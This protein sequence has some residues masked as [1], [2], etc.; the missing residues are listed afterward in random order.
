MRRFL[1]LLILALVSMV[2]CAKVSIGLVTSCPSDREVYTLWG[3]TAL[4]VQTDST[5]DVYNYGVFEFSDDFIYKFVSGQTDYCLDKGN[6]I[7]MV[8]EIA[9]KRTYGY[10]QVLN[11]SDEQAEQMRSALEENLKPENRYYRYKFFSDNCATRP[12]RLIERVV[13]EV[14][15]PELYVSSYGAESYRSIIHRLCEREPWLRLGID[16]CLG[17]EADEVVPD[18]MYT[19]LPVSLMGFFD[20]AE[21]KGEDGVWR[22]LVKQKTCIYKPYKEERKVVSFYETPLFASLCLL[23]L[24]VMVFALS[25]KS[26]KMF[27]PRFF[28]GVVLLAFGVLGLLIFYLVFFSTHECT[29]PNFNLMWMNPL[30]LVSAV[31]LFLG[32]RGIFSKVWLLLDILLLSA[33]LL[34]IGFL[35][36]STCWEFLL[37][38]ISL[39][40]SILAF[41]WPERRSFLDFFKKKTLL[42]KQQIK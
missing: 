9:W 4:L 37:I 29:S 27:F 28:G 3:H 36:Q 14:R 22:P 10:L 12:Q 34:L 42:D 31:L 15:Y 1:S 16:M 7:D 40:I 33:Y 32:A 19:F 20:G 38:S 26:G 25:C 30:H 24:V 21:V 18:S 41:V 23:L 2:A 8:N 6:P 13:G 11:L 17:S 35:P 39:I 5:S